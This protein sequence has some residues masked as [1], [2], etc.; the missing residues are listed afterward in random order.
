MKGLVLNVLACAFMVT[1][2]TT[3]GSKGGNSGIMKMTTEVDDEI[4]F[5]LCGSGVVTV[6]WGDG[7]EK[8]ILTLNEECVEFHH[9]YTDAKIHEIIIHGDQMVSMRCD[10]CELTHLDVSQ[11]TALTFLDCSNNQLAR[12]DMSANSELAYLNCSY[13]QLTRLDMSKNTALAYL[14]CSYNQ[15]T[16]LD[17]S[18]NMALTIL[19]CQ[20]N[21]LTTA[22]LQ[23]LFGSLHDNTIPRETKEIHIYRNEGENDCDR[24]IA[25]NKG[26]S[27]I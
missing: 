8:E 20:A 13:N 9:H 17:M 2:F 12:L 18:Q 27:V 5:Y 7:S 21:Q 11:N 15:L 25:I 19:V 14:D 16:S 23:A 24:S 10:R 22:A 6:D 26:W 4:E 3:C 1:A